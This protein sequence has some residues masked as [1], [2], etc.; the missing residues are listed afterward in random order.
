MFARA[1]AHTTPSPHLPSP[2]V[3]VSAGLFE[4]CVCKTPCKTQIVNKSVSM[5]EVTHTNKI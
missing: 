4:V 1:G 2:P 5:I 3:S